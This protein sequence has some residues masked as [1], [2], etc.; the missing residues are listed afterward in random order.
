MADTASP[1]QPHVYFW[2]ELCD[3]DVTRE[4]FHFVVLQNRH[5]GQARRQVRVCVT[6]AG[7]WKTPEVVRWIDAPAIYPQP[8]EQG[9]DS[10]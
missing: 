7:H 6:C 5:T 8:E 1:R 10:E 4:D 2:C 9:E 3:R